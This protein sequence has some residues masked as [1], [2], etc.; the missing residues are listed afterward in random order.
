MLVVPADAEPASRVAER[1]KCDLC[2]VVSRDLFRAA[3]GIQGGGFGPTG[4]KMKGQFGA[5]DL[6]DVVSSLCHIEATPDWDEEKLGLPVSR[7]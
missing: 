6:V 7:C 3:I 1:I 5:G 4:F 2:G